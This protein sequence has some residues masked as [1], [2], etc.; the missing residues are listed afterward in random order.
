MKRPYQKMPKIYFDDYCLRTVKRS[1]AKDMYEYGKDPEVTCF[2]SWGPFILLG[3]AKKSIVNIFLPRLSEELPI[4]YAIIDRK[5]PKM[6]GTID[7]HSK[8]KG[9]NGAEIGFVL[10]KNYWNKGIMTKALQKMVFIG[11]DYLNFDIIKIKHLKQNIASQKVI[12]KVGFKFVK[13]ELFILEK[14]DHVVKDELLT[15]ELT[16]EDYYGNQQS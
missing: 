6:I 5:I 10:H 2:L 8:I 12:Q 16:K 4:G 15:Y 13:T 14:R 1:D 9:V 7:F 3:E 11:F